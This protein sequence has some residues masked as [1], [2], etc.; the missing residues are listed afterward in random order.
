ME[1]TV[2]SSSHL[3]A[4]KENKA[5]PCLR[6]LAFVT[7]FLAT[8]GL[9]GL[10]YLLTKEAEVSQFHAEYHH[11][12]MKMLEA[13]L[14][15]HARLGAVIGLSV[16]CSA[17][18]RDHVRAWPFVTLSS[19]G[20]Q[21]TIAIKQSGALLLHVNHYVEG[22]SVE[23]WEKFVAGLDRYWINESL[24][25]QK[26][27]YQVG[28]SNGC[29]NLGGMP[30][31]KTLPIWHR[32]G[33]VSWSEVEG[34]G[35]FLVRWQSAPVLCGGSQVNE[36]VSV[37]W[38]DTGGNV[39]FHSEAV[40]FGGFQVATP[41]GGNSSGLTKLFSMLLSAS[42]GRSTDYMGDPFNQ[43]YIP[44]FDVPD[45]NDRKAAAVMTVWIQ[46]LSYFQDVLPP[47]MSGIILVLSNSCSGS[48]TYQVD[49]DAVTPL[50]WGDRHDPF[51][52]NLRANT[53]WDGFVN[54]GD[55][56]K[57]GLPLNKDHCRMSL[58]VFPSAKTHR[59]YTTSAPATLAAVVAAVLAF[60][61][62]TFVLHLWAVSRNELLAS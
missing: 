61:A 58:D 33:E 37:D 32:R 11:A 36:E 27:V 50:G 17:H 23:D 53:N 45:R 8:I 20:Q 59:M 40:T 57:D 3:R 18:A 12:S 7:L 52:D 22:E 10:V 46:W 55:G 5:V 25:Y 56:T 1:E 48:F 24:D 49:G 60:V 21:G 6:I 28:L 43:V 4:R 30:A 2:A 47:N 62:G 31:N 26:D 41:T 54:F 15:I 44:I 13:F 39:S 51:Y 34:Q 16:R 29:Q 38:G 42:Y 35:P 19:F 14:G 9:S